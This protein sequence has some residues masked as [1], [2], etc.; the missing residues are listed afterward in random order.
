MQKGFTLIEIL[1]VI[2]LLGVLAVALLATIDPLEQIR[3]G[4]DSK[5]ESIIAELQGAFQRYYAT[6]QEFPWQATNP[7]GVALSAANANVTAVV[8]AGEVKANFATVAGATLTQIF[9]TGTTTNVTLCY[10]PTSKAE[11]F[12]KNSIYTNNGG[13]GAGCK[14][15]ATPGANTCYWC[16]IN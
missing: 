1:I 8:N 15:A 2:A 5:T 7:S 6:R 9:L 10:L 12:N 13:A 4:N 3:K 14:G 11:A 16:V